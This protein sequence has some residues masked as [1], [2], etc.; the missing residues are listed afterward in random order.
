LKSKIAMAAIL[1]VMAV[2]LATQ[3]MITDVD[4]RRN[5]R[6]DVS[7]ENEQT[8]VGNNNM[9]AGDDVNANSENCRN[10]GAQSNNENNVLADRG[11]EIRIG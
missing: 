8:G 1:A 5:N 9:Q 3:Y 6:A 7:S 2:A 11:G 4:A 10:C